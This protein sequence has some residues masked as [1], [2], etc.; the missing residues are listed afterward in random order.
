[1]DRNIF[2]KQTQLLCNS[3]F[4]EG[5]KDQNNINYHALRT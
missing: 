2:D 4:N 1:M 5:P 3:L